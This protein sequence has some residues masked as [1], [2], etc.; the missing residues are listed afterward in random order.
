[1]DTAQ[2]A[3][4]A[5]LLPFNAALAPYLQHWIDPLSVPASPSLLSLPALLIAAGEALCAAVPSSA[6]CSNPRC[7]NLSGV[8]AGFALVRGKGCVC[9]GCLG[10]Q[11]GGEAAVTSQGA[12][13]L[14]GGRC[15][16]GAGESIT[17]VAPACCFASFVI[18]PQIRAIAGFPW[19]CMVHTCSTPEVQQVG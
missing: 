5:A 12:H 16:W 9:G 1:L 17:S 13:A 6:C 2:S 11:V 8:S 7:N 18:L 19:S 3:L 4:K 15:H 14:A 10:L